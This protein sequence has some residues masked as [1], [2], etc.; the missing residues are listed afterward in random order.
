MLRAH[1]KDNGFLCK[2][3]LVVWGATMTTAQKCVRLGLTG[4]ISHIIDNNKEKEGHFFVCEKGEI[5]IDRV[6][7]LNNLDPKECCLIVSSVN[8]YEQIIS[9][10]HAGY[11]LW[12]NSVVSIDCLY[13][14]Y[15]SLDELFKLDYDYH[16]RILNSCIL[17]SIEKYQIIT[18]DILKNFFVTECHLIQ[19]STGVVIKVQCKNEAYILKFPNWKGECSKRQIAEI[20][21][22]KE[23]IIG[24]DEFTLYED[25]EGFLLCK[26]A[27]KIQKW[28]A[29]EIKHALAILK[30]IEQSNVKIGRKVNSPAISS[31]EHYIKKFSNFDKMT[32]QK[33][34]ADIASPSEKMVISHSDPHCANFLMKDGELYLIDW[35]SL[36]M[37]YELY[38][39][40][41]FI[42]DLWYGRAC[43]VYDTWED[44]LLEYC[45]GTLDDSKMRWARAKMILITMNFE[46]RF[47]NAGVKTDFITQ[48]IKKSIEE[49]VFRYKL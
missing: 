44:I 42:A 35:N 48:E 47:E 4:K 18:K 19:E 45:G 37:N 38:D 28:T 36:K 30:K 17:S 22:V 49:Y 7:I 15:N 10:I 23:K 5:V 39:T 46:K 32:M 3:K 34:V 2:K 8:S 40:L 25:A 21:F 41:Y 43:R 11:K 27:E 20:A 6:D 31:I 33:L 26:E 1:G 9:Q 24:K 29:K 16:Q 14:V 12:A 13:N